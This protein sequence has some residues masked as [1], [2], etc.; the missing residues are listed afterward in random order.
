VV[1]C[2]IE[3]LLDLNMT[4]HLQPLIAGVQVDLVVLDVLVV[5][6]VV[7][8]PAVDLQ[9]V[10]VVF[11]MVVLV[12]FLA[13]VQ[14]NVLT[15]QA[16]R[17]VESLNG[18]AGVVHLSNLEEAQEQVALGHMD[19]DHHDFFSFYLNLITKMLHLND[20]FSSS[21]AQLNRV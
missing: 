15:A 4:K 21:Y 13:F 19:Q 9:Q 11:G 5:Q 7:V 17:D 3:V 18:L 1:D 2:Q 10:S 14:R 20:P 16:K 12:N 6:L 8:L